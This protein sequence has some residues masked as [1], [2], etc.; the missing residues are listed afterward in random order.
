[1]RTPADVV[2]STPQFAQLALHPG[3]QLTNII[4]GVIAPR[5]TCLVGDQEDV[6][7]TM[8]QQANCVKDTVRPN[9]AFSRADIAIVAVQ[10]AVAIEKHGGATDTRRDPGPGP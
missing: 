5:N 7:A 10:N 1:M 6:I 3:V 2:Y 8:V 9:E 4:V